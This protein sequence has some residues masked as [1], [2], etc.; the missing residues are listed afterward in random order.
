MEG[1]WERRRRL[2]SQVGSARAISSAATLVVIA[3]RSRKAALCACVTSIAL[4]L[5][6]AV[7]V[8][9]VDVTSCFTDAWSVVSQATA[10]TVRSA[11]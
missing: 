11:R 7:A 5:T 9:V 4:T 2:E 6:M 3:T 1:L 10:T 8:E